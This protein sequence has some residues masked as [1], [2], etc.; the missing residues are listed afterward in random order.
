MAVSLDGAK[1]TLIE[2]KAVDA[3]YPLYGAVSLTPVQ[4]LADALAEE[5]WKATD[6]LRGAARVYPFFLADDVE[7]H[8][9]GQ[10]T[11]VR[12]RALIRSDSPMLPKFR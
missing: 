9:E 6:S 12:G 10:A 1:H 8:T 3:A 5:I 2:L 4:P 7:F 11:T